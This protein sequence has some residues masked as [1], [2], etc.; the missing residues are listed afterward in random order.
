MTSH[1][2]M[3]WWDTANDANASTR[4]RF[5][6]GIACGLA[7]W[8]CAAQEGA[9]QG[10]RIR[11]AADEEYRTVIGEAGGETGILA[12]LRA[13]ATTGSEAIARPLNAAANILKWYAISIGVLIAAVILALII[14]FVALPLAG[15]G[16]PKR[17]ALSG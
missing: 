14:W 16:G 12:E 10:Q 5:L 6:A 2:R 4:D 1:R 17:G 3:T 8:Q 11:D 15:L 7:P 9:Q 13:T